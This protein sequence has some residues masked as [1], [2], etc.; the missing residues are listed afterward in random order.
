MKLINLVRTLLAAPFIGLAW[1]S[2]KLY[3][4]IDPYLNWELERY[5]DYLEIELDEWDDDDLDCC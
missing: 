3:E 5:P 4:F 1:V 2:Y